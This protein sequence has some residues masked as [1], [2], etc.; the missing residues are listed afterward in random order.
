MPA[1]K[2]KCA[3]CAHSWRDNT[4]TRELPR[5]IYI[6]NHSWRPTTKFSFFFC[7]FVNTLPTQIPE[8]PYASE[9]HSA[10]LTAFNWYMWLT[11]RPESYASEHYS[12]VFFQP[13]HKVCS[14]CND[15]PAVYGILNHFKCP[16][17]IVDN[18]IGSLHI[19]TVNYYYTLS[20]MSYMHASAL[21]L[22]EQWKAHSNADCTNTHTQTPWVRGP[23]CISNPPS[24]K[25]TQTQTYAR[26]EPVPQ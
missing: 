4:R 6:I 21:R 17:N 3:K 19:R 12:R 26:I 16:W 15:N 24:C 1:D 5:I 11:P 10:W 25:Q 23:P 7:W 9:C 22:S 14:R 13:L 20:H 18:R 8:N 2:K